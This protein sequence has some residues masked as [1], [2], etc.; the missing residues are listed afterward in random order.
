MDV[1]TKL[2][3]HVCLKQLRF[4]ESRVVQN[5]VLVDI[6]MMDVSV[7]VGLIASTDQKFH[8]DIQEFRVRVTA[9]DSGFHQYLW[10]LN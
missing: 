9:E 6:S 1:G 5:K 8:E 7:L 3:Y 2:F 10:K 4:L